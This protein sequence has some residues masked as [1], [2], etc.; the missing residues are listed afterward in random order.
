MPVDAGSGEGQIL[1]ME[2][3]GPAGRIAG[4]LGRVACRVRQAGV[5]RRGEAARG[6]APPVR[7]TGAMQPLIF[8]VGQ[9]RTRRG[10]AYR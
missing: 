3:S 1:E 9:P 6:D 5:D 7:T 2:R 4:I 8:R 10:H